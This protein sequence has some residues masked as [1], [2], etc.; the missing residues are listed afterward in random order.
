MFTPGDCPA[1]LVSL[2]VAACVLWAV[3]RA[4][5]DDAP[6]AIA[7][8]Y[9]ASSGCPSQSTFREAVSARTRQA[10][11]A[12]PTD[13][14]SQTLE[15]I[16]VSSEGTFDG[17]LRMG[18]VG[19]QQAVRRISGAT[20][21]EVMA[22][23][24]LVAALAIDPNALTQPLPVSPAAPGFA[25][26]GQTKDATGAADSSGTVQ[27]P[28]NPTRGPT[29]PGA[30][31]APANGVASAVATPSPTPR[32]TG[33]ATRYSRVSSVAWSPIWAN[34]PPERAWRLAVGTD[35]NE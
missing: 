30:V 35:G 15:I 7:L 11:W 9:Y 25:N 18:R 12:A 16:L 33:Q 14:P 8:T 5:A 31:P 4:N 27:A 6:G 34:T 21:D 2:S 29:Q 24:A 3:T 22:A 20:C 28:M 13:V 17:H 26:N 19:E 10:V 1:W 32:S 23:L